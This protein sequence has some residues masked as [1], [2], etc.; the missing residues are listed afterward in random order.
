[1]SEIQCYNIISTNRK[2]RQEEVRKEEQK[3]QDHIKNDPEKDKIKD[4]IR[5]AEAR[6]LYV[7][8]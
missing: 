3:L 8:L 2:K 5:D 7:W 6:R 1:M 4:I